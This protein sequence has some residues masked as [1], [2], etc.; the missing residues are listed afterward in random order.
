M[1]STGEQRLTIAKEFI[2]DEVAETLLDAAGEFSVQAGANLIAELSKKYGAQV[3]TRAVVAAFYAVSVG[4]TLG[5]LLYG[6]DALFAN[7]KL[8]ERAEELR[9]TFRAGRL[10]LQR[11][12]TKEKGVAQ[13]S[14]VY[15]GDLAEKFRAAYLLETLSAV[16]TQRAYADGVAAT[17][18]LPNPA[19]FINWLRGQDWK[20]AVEGL[21]KQADVN[22]ANVLDEIGSPAYL[23]TAVA[24]ALNRT[25]LKAENVGNDDQVPYSITVQANTK[26]QDTGISV[27]AGDAIKITYISGHWSIWL[28]VDPLTDGNGQTGRS[29]ICQLI[30]EA[31]LGSLIGKVG[32]GAP[33]FVGNGT[34]MHSD[35]TGPLLLSINDC[36]NFQDNG[37]FLTVDI[38][39]AQ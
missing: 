2:T 28:N 24:L 11:Q 18:Q 13:D 14:F 3:S 8:A 20:V 17:F 30:P 38:A 5:S 35:S 29:E 36:E 37:G 26:W 12:A 32:A 21:R 16:Q 27:H 10:S 33:F 15:N 7:F 31:N 9:T 4:T 1:K 34:T 22:E 23:D 19:Q 25:Q 39:V 6:T